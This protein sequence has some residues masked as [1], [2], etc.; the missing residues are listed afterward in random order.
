MRRLIY[1]FPFLWI[2]LGIWLF[3]ASPDLDQLVRERGQFDIP[4]NYQTAVTAD[5][6]AENEGASGEEILLVY[7]EDDGF[8]EDQLNSVEDTLNDFPEEI[9]GFPVVDITSPF[10]N[11]ESSALISDDETTLMAVITLDMT[12][13]DVPTVRP[14]VEAAALNEEVETF[15]SGE[16]IIEDDVIISSEEGLATTE[17]ITVVFV[18]TI[19]LFVFRSVV[20]PLVPLVTVGAAYFITIPVVSFMIDGWDFPVSNFTQIFIVAILFGI[21]TDYC[22]L[23]LNRFKEEL[24]K[25]DNRVTAVKE[26]YRAVGPT[27]FSSALTGFIG[28]AA[29]GLA[30]FDLYQSAAGVAVGIVLLVLALVVWVPVAMLLLGEKIFWPSKRALEDTD[31]RIWKGLGK[32]SFVR[33][34]WTSLILIALLVPSFL[35]YEQRLSFHSLDEI[36]SD[37]ESV[38]A[39][40]IVSDR[41]GVGHSFPVKVVMES[42]EPWNQSE[43]LPVIEQVSQQVSM[44]EEVEEVRSFSRPDGETVEEF[45]I[46]YLMGEAADGT[47]EMEEGLEEII[48]GLN[49]LSENLREEQDATDEAA[50]GAAD[51]AEGSAELQEGLNESADG[52]E[53]SAAGARELAAAQGNIAEEMAGIQGA[54]AEIA[55]NPALDPQTAGTLEELSGGLNE[56]ETGLQETAGGTNELAEGQE[57]IQNGISEAAAGQTE[58]SDGQTDLAEGFSDIG[59][60]FV[61]I[62]D[63]VDEIAEGTEEILEGMEEVN[64]LLDE[65]ASQPAHPLEGFYVP[66]EAFEDDEMDELTSAFTTPNELV[67]TLDVVLAIDPYSNAAMDTVNE[68]D[69]QIARALSE[70][71]DE[72]RYSLGGLP[73]TNADLAEISD[74]DFYRTAAIMLSGIFLVLVVMLRSLIMPVYILASL[75]GTYIISM[76][77]TELIFVTIL[78]Y[79]GIS[80]AVPFFGF[81]MLMALG[82]DYSI[83]LMGRFAENMKDHSVHDALLGAMTKIGTVILSAAI[84]LAGTFGAMMPSGVLS[85]VQI[86]TLVLT[87]LLLYAFV[88]LP[89]FIPLMVRLFGE[90]N[91][92]PF[93][94][95]GRK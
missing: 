18:I 24:A 41:F 80:W 16:A 6:L 44:I 69:E 51:L 90:N 19:L 57:E 95:P 29:I 50:D 14:D 75:I 65:I 36:G 26:T 74:Q 77:V 64:E 73:A 93:K 82:V 43:M 71:P 62:A 39:I 94:A 88:M 40:E 48:D 79:P 87:G 5:I 67:T 10:E 15:V 52:L 25:Q 60:A 34:G 91:W 45:S 37:F 84:I 2:G 78:G 61:E 72:F 28:F 89:L 54:I 20:A 33:P 59:E 46:P 56:L 23:L 55:Q 21:G 38:E 42:E 31:S 83:F 47:E 63:A 35:F 22:I 4:D 12:L 70:W 8:T 68:I 3:L 13:N 86:G 49:E 1:I 30:D 58:I 66:A 81:V 17:I 76:A 9:Q 92:L 11:E 85:L 53:E 32:F 27:V 7:V